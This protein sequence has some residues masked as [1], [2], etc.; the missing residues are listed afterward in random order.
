MPREDEG[1]R[2]SLAIHRTGP[3]QEVEQLV[4]I[5]IE[6][7]SQGRE[8]EDAGKGSIAHNAPDILSD[9]PLA[10]PNAAGKWMSPDSRDRSQ[11]ALYCCRPGPAY[12]GLNRL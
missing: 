3:A 1:A 10:R 7:R 4:R 12:L 9:A 5:G 11:V 6:I 2:L 8:L